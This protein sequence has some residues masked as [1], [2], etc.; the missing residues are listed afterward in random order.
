MIANPI[1]LYSE[2][3]IDLRSLSGPLDRKRGTYAD[4]RLISNAQERLYTE[5]IGTD[6]VIWCSPEVPVT[7]P[8]ETPQYIHTIEADGRDIIAVLDGFLWEHIIGNDRCVPPEVHARMRFSC[9][10]ASSDRDA[11]LRRLEYDY[12]ATNLP[13]D[14]WASVVVSDI[15]H[16]M[17]Q[18]LLGWPLKKSRISDVRTIIRERMCGY[19]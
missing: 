1:K 9:C 11:A 15:A 19:L 18:I 5:L 6:Q 3:G 13:A 10:S 14:P 7:V 17:A 2:Q 4:Q 12:I 8:L 16:P